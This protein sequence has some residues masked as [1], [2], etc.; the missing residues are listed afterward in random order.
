M[1]KVEKKEELNSDK[2]VQ[3]QTKYIVVDGKCKLTS[4]H[5]KEC[6]KKIKETISPDKEIVFILPNEKEVKYE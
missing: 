3:E 6:L 5:T 1:S 2:K 4:Y